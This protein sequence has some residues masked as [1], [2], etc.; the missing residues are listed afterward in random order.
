MQFRGNSCFDSRIMAQAAGHPRLIARPRFDSRL[1]HVK[2]EVDA[3]A[4]GQGFLAGHFRFPLPISLHHCSTFSHLHINTI[5]I[6]R[7]NGRRLGDFRK[8]RALLGKEEL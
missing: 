6:R 7:T 1:V 3:V 5:I 8:H 2:F 4:L